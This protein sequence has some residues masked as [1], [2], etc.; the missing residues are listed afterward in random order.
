MGDHSKALEFY[1]KDLQIRKI[2][3]LP[4]THPDLAISY[5]CISIAY[6]IIVD[7]QKALAFYEK[8][9]KITEKPRPP[10]HLD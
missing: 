2:K 4:P 1:E 8:D 3:L 7:Y 5:A 10:S 6:N 9:L